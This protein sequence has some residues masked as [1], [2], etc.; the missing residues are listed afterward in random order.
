[1]M[2]Y[3]YA[4]C[5]ELLYFCHSFIASRTDKPRF[6]IN[7]RTIMTQL[8]RLISKYLGSN[9]NRTTSLVKPQKN[10]QKAD[11]TFMF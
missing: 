6:L 11:V 1:M 5:N 3:D 7:R 8:I 9:G 2:S 4:N 10:S